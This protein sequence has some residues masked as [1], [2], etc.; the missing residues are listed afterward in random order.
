[1]VEEQRQARLSGVRVMPDPDDIDDETLQDNARLA[2]LMMGLAVKEVSKQMDAL[3]E[4]AAVSSDNYHA[5]IRAHMSAQVQL[6]GQD[7]LKAVAIGVQ[8]IDASD[9][10]PDLSTLQS[11]MRQGLDEIKDSINELEG[12]CSTL[13]DE[14]LIEENVDK[15]AT[16]TGDGFSAVVDAI[17]RLNTR[18]LVPRR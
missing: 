18:P 5:Y 15:L 3:Q 14:C 1:M 4:A 7:Q 10:C 6:L 9:A 13:R 12:M 8:S 16:A 2:S 11:V 17:K